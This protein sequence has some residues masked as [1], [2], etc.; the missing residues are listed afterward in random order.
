MTPLLA[1]LGIGL[2]VALVCGRALPAADA[3]PSPARQP[4][5]RFDPL[6]PDQVD[7]AVD[8]AVAYLVS[9]QGA[10]GAISSDRGSSNATAMTSLAIMAMAAVGHQPPDPTPAGEALRKGL[11]FILRDGRQNAEGY[12]GQHDGSR[13][14]GHGITT[15]MLSELLGMGVD[16]PQDQLI[17]QRCQKAVDLILRAQQVRKHANHAGGWRYEPKSPD[18]DLSVTVWQVM[19]LRSAKNAG[20]DVPGQAIQQ[21]VEYLQR[22]YAARSSRGERSRGEAPGGFSYQPGG[23]QPT[24]A[25]TAAGLLAMQVCGQYDAAEVAGAARWLADRPVE[26]QTRWF[27]YGLYY[28]AQGMYQRGGQ[29]ADTARKTVENLLLA[30]QRPDG[31]WEPHDSTERNTGPVY[32]TAM[33]VLSLS[34]KYHYLPIYQR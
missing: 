11:A 5:T 22:S 3:P 18:A 9:R 6:G 7:L 12:F 24:F 13:M 27:F 32:A 26:W 19:A 1:W 33:A 15:L 34:V 10:S 30:H 8:Q 20:L 29:Y 23:R 16:A 21:A 31:S 17:R 25:M 14:Y 28:Y 4:A 2:L